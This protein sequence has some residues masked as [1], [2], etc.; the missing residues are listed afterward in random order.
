MQTAIWAGI[1]LRKRV[2]AEALASVDVQTCWSAWHESGSEPAKWDPRTKET[3]DH[4]LPY[5]LAWTLR[6]GQ[7]DEESF[8]PESYLDP[9]IRPLMNIITARVD[10]DI[11]KDMPKTIRMRVNAKDK[12]GKSH[13]VHIVNPPGHEENPLSPAD[14]AAKFTR[15][16]EP[17]L[18]KERAA[19]ALKHWQNIASARNVK[20]AFDAVNV[21]E[22]R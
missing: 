7:I 18:G 14:L 1:E 12:A 5:I 21:T 19:A 20:D 3:A 8:K 9:S 17:R 22:S 4:S 15:L 10:D 13:E 2:P 11:E 6:H 16:I